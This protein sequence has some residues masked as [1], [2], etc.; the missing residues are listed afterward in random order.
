LVAVHDG[1][2]MVSKTKS[3]DRQIPLLLI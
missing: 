1:F 3:P 2:S